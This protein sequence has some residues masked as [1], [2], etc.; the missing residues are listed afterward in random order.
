MRAPVLIVTVLVLASST[1][2]ARKARETKPFA[3][4]ARVPESARARPNPLA[5]DPDAVRAGAKLYERHCAECH[6]PAG[7]NGR[8]G[9][10]LRAPELQAASDGAV[11]WVITNGNVR[12]GMPVWS[13]LPEPQRWQLTTYVKSLPATAP[14]ESDRAP[15]R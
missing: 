9:P 2:L 8:K 14:P 7:E 13:R 6:G 11:F 5:H 15:A 10:G 4:L 3:Q 12:G 1:A